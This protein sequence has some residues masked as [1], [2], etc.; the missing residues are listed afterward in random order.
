MNDKSEVI[1]QQHWN[2]FYHGFEL[3]IPSQFACCV[4]TDLRRSNDYVVE[5]G[6]GN[7]RDAFFFSEKGFAITATDRSPDVIERNLGIQHARKVR[8]ISFQ[9]MDVSDSLTVANCIRNTNEHKS[10]GKTIIA[11]SRFFLHSLSEKQ[12]DSFLSG[13]KDSLVKGDKFYAE[14]RCLADE[15][16]SKEFG[17]HYRRFIDTDSLLSDLKSK[18]GF[19]IDYNHSGQGMARFR[20]EDAWVS[21]IIATRV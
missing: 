13:L 16:Q 10:L 1:K 12:Q 9:L 20:G 4:A 7:A 18:Y 5:F 21:R 19:V 6:C 8:N 11:Y 3:S 14:Y 15:C 17:E 2:S